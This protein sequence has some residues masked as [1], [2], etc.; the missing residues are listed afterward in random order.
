MIFLLVLLGPSKL[1]FFQIE[2]EIQGDGVSFHGSMYPNGDNRPTHFDSI[3]SCCYIH[4]YVTGRR[5]HYVEDDIFF[6]VGE[7]VTGR[8]KYI[9][10]LYNLFT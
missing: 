5:K 8:R 4:V 1:T 6:K 10:V 7:D 2:F 3:S 9:R